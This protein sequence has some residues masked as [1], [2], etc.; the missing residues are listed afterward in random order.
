MQTKRAA[1]GSVHTG[2]RDHKSGVRDLL[3]GSQVQEGHHVQHKHDLVESATV[4]GDRH[5][6]AIVERSEEQDRVHA[7]SQDCCV[8]WWLAE[9][10][11]QD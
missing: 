7:G 10:K 8:L 6:S 5:L 9:D 3:C 1:V 4:Q 2:W 11:K